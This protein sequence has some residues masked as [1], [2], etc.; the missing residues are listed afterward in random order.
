L[1]DGIRTVHAEF[2]VDKKTRVGENANGRSVGVSKKQ[3]KKKKKNQKKKKNNKK[4]PK[5]KKKPQP[6]KKKKKNK[7]PKKK[8]HR[9]NPVP[10]RGKN[11]STKWERLRGE[12]KEKFKFRGAP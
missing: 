7:Q 12:N 3:R 1:G 8:P 6:K 5:K 9:T 11:D 2:R 10:L 4:N